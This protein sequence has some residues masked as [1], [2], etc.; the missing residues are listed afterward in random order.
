MNFT[1]RHKRVK[2]A[3]FSITREFLATTS[4]EYNVDNMYGGMIKDYVIE[5]GASDDYNDATGM[6]HDSGY[7]RNREST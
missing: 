2:T 7:H 4:G 6:H 3:T 1:K 5:R